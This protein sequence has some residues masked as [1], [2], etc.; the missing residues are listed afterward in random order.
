MPCFYLLHKIAMKVNEK[1]YKHLW[2]CHYYR[3][4]FP[5]TLS[6]KMV[7]DSL[8]FV[9]KMH[10]LFRLVFSIPKMCS[11][12]W[13]ISANQRNKYLEQFPKYC[14]IYYLSKVGALWSN[15]MNFHF[16]HVICWKLYPKLHVLTIKSHISLIIIAM[17]FQ[18]FFFFVLW[19]FSIAGWYFV[20]SGW[21]FS[22]Q[23][24]W[25][26]PRKNLMLNIF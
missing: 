12:L 17:L 4:Y 15:H 23:S 9:I 2:E 8:L 14:I 20:F 5:L 6:I 26:H 3:E 10:V 19:Y 16:R 13:A 18:F 25:Q 22:C 11:N 7:L 21:I 24:I 1:H